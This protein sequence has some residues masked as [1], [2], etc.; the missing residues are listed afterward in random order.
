MYPAKFACDDR[1]SMDWALVILG[2]SSKENILI[3]FFKSL[4]ILS[5]FKW[6]K[7]LPINTAPSLIDA[8]SESLGQLILMIISEVL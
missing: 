1:I 2:S 7:K 4:L 6:G 8:I 5:L 3:F